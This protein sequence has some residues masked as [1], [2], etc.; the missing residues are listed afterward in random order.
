[1]EFHRRKRIY[2]RLNIAPMIDVVLLLL[3][4]FMLSAHFVMQPGIKVSLPKSTTAGSE[5]EQDVVVYM[6]ARGQTVLDGRELTMAQLAEALQKR[7]ADTDRR[8]VVVKPDASVPMGAVVQVMDAAKRA[9]A[10]DMVLSTQV[11]EPAE[12]VKP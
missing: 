10:Q 5:E 7:L 3:I 12:P 8:R 1:M 11:A 9:G 6:G 4:F 2:E